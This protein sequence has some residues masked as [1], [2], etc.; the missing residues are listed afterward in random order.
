MEGTRILA[1]SPGSKTGFNCF[2]FDSKVDAREVVKE[3]EGRCPDYRSQ[4][5]YSTCSSY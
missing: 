1:Y 3:V 5:C 4:V 2:H